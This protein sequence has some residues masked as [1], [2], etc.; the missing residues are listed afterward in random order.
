MRHGSAAPSE[1]PE[2]G[3]VLSKAFLRA[4]EKLGLVQKEQARILGL[5]PASLSRLSRG[6][7]SID[8]D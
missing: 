3:A 5:S 4:S 1:A 6:E 8:V 2:A 7:R